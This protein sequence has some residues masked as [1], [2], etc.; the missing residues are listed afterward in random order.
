AL[1][2]SVDLTDEMVEIVTETPDGVAADTFDVGGGG[3]V[4]VDTT[5][6]ENVESE[7]YARDII[8]RIQ[9]MR[10]DMDLDLEAEITVSIDIADDRVAEFV[11]E[12]EALIAEEVRAAA[13]GSV[14]DGHRREWEIEE[15]SVE[16]AI[17]PV[18]EAR[19]D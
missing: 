10:K 14:A 5:L 18:A 2:E 1:G 13:F 17:V 6:T 9:E 19:A 11:R 3:T 12:H 15:T 7:G 4:Y 16:I 8:R